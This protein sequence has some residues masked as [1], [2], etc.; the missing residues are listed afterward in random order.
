MKAQLATAVVVL[1]FALAPVA[2]YAADKADPG[3]KKET[4][5]EKAKEVISDAKITTTVKAEYAKDKAVSAMKINVDTDKGV[6][7]LSGTAKSKD[8]ADKA[9]SIAKG[10]KGVVSVKND[11]KVEAGKK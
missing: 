2:G 3:T 6:V 9:E 7:R 5:S 11:I 1:G 8:E 10:V 4:T